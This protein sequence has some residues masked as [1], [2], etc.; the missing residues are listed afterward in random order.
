MLIYGTKFGFPQLGPATFFRVKPGSGSRKG[1]FH[2]ALS[3]SV[4]HSAG[5]CYKC[6]CY[7]ARPRSHHSPCLLFQLSLNQ[8]FIFL[9]VDHCSLQNLRR[10]PKQHVLSLRP[11]T[12]T[13]T[14]NVLARFFALSLRFRWCL[15]AMSTLGQ[16]HLKD[17]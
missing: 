9:H 14:C 2:A 3:L 16:S 13:P 7:S 6:T 1:N 12:W 17:P 11:P 4:Q 5:G 10:S 8:F 15:R